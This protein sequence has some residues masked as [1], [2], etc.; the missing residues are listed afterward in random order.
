M[1]SSKR[2]SE[3]PL[4]LTLAELSAVLDDAFPAAARP[5]YG[6]V[7]DVRP[8]HIRM[9]L[10]PDPS[11]TRPGGYV[12]G[13]AL[14][15][16]ADVAAYAVVLAHVGVVPMAVTQHFAI[17]FLRP[18]RRETIV[19]DAALLKLGRRVAAVDVRLWQDGEERLIAQASVGYA[20]P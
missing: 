2:S 7:V 12:A 14:M 16:L 8:G 6:K 3:P 15:G 4:R 9:A 17:T 1:P 11:M 19:A 18:C 5:S 20:L 10:E 13:P